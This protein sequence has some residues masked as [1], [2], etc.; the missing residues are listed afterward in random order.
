MVSLLALNLFQVPC[1]L[2]EVPEA[3]RYFVEGHVRGKIVITM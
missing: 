1:P 3:F 2:S